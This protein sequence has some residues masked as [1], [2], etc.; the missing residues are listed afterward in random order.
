[1]DLTNQNLNKKQNK[2][3]D[4]KYTT[5]ASQRDSSPTLNPYGQSAT[6]LASQ[7]LTQSAR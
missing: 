2:K 6:G 5:T 4:G 7:L 3:I 1:M